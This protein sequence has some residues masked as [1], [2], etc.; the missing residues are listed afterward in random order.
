MDHAYI[1]RQQSARQGFTLVEMLVV[2]SII[3]VIA[4]MVVGLAGGAARKNKIARVQTDLNK[5][6]MAIE[7]FKNKYGSY[8]PDNSTF[9]M[10]GNVT[11]YH[12]G[13]N[14]LFYELTGTTYNA[15]NDSFRSSM[16]GDELTAA[17]I[18]NVVGARGF[19]NA[20]ED[21]KDTVNFLPNLAL[22]QVKRTKI[23]NVDFSL[24][25]VPVSLPGGAANYWHYRS[26]NPTNNPTS[27][28]LW[29]VVVM[30]KQTNIIKNW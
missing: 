23:K 18:A 30:G 17:N 6:V 7:N 10:S 12:T 16:Q 29:A 26:T 24:L 1:N 13:T 2:I 25:L 9:T 11:N 5:L 15:K 14:Q 4:G 28:D 22:S 8:P 3:A 21:I 20:S 27:F 19:R